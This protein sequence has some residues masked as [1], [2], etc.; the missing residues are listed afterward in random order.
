MCEKESINGP[1]NDKITDCI[2]RHSAYCYPGCYPD[3][4]ASLQVFSE[5][6]CFQSSFVLVGSFG[7][8]SWYWYECL[9]GIALRE[10]W[11]RN[12]RA[13]GPTEKPG[14]PRSILPR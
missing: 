1:G 3:G 12:P 10:V 8:E 13:L 6:G 9:D 5:I 14:C 7:S 4:I 2:T 11:R